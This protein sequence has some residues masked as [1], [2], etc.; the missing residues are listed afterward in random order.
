[1]VL[2]SAVC[3]QFVPRCTGQRPNPDLLAAQ[4]DRIVALAALDSVSLAVLPLGEPPDTVFWHN[5][6]IFEG[7]EPYVMIEL[8]HT[9]LTVTDPA[10]VDTYRRL[11]KRIWERSATDHEAVE[12]IRRIRAGLRL[13]QG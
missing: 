8:T 9:A 12:L 6:M 1:M 10:Q 2:G 3:T 5:F 13:R 11:Y 7:D 4:L